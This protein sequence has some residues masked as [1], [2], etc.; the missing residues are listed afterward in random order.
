MET[1]QNL[2]PAVHFRYMTAED[3]SN[4][5]SYVYQ[6][7]R[8]ETDLDYLRDDIIDLIRSAFSD[9]DAGLLRKGRFQECAFTQRRLI[10]MMETAF[11]IIQIAP[12]IVFP[13][14]HPWQ[15][16]LRQPA[17]PD[18]TRRPR[19]GYFQQFLILNYEEIIHPVTSL[20]AF[21]SYRTLEEWRE[22]LDDLLGYA[23][24]ES[25]PIGTD[26]QGHAFKI[27][28][29]LER[30]T[31]TL[32]VVYEIRTWNDAEETIE[33]DEG[34]DDDRPAKGNDIRENSNTEKTTNVLSP[35]F[36]KAVSDYFELFSPDFLIANYRRL[37]LKYLELMI[38]T[39]DSSAT[40]DLPR[41]SY[42]MAVFLELLDTA[43]KE[44]PPAG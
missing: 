29:E 25:D 12:K 19:S 41:F 10:K 32:Y 42:Q 11:R 35:G 5:F 33:E 14:A 7:F 38:V 30:L 26:E 2:F 20:T 28:N 4:P 40:G 3:F 18:R 9:Q 24:D 22:I 27:V 34:D 37:F 8:H 13:E 16:T 36:Q 1:N 43:K 17:C 31:E 39:P 15:K 21:F 6:L 23:Y 44:Y